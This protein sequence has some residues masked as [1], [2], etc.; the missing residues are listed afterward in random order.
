[1]KIWDATTGQETLSHEGRTGELYGVAWSPDGTRLASGAQEAHS[2][3]VG[4][5]VKVWDPTTGQEALTLKGHMA[6]VS[7]V[8]WSPDGRRLASASPDGTVKVWAGGR[9]E[10]ALR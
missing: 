3:S 8:A 2:A 6:V 9:P 7:G 4:G 5:T 10:G 1:V